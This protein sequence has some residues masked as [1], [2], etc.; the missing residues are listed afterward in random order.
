MYFNALP[1][2]IQKLARNNYVLLKTNPAYRSL[3]FKQVCNGRYLSVRI[4][5]HYR[6]LGVSVPDGVQW[7]WIGSHEEYNKLL[8]KPL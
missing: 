2:Q 5:L 3:Y 1:K 8:S 7:F 6:A 4:G